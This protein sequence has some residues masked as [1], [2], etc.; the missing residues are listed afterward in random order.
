[1]NTID[2]VEEYFGDTLTE[3]TTERISA[4]P[5][6][7][8]VPLVEK[9]DAHY[10]DWFSGH[11]P[12]EQG[13]TE[14]DGDS[15]FYCLEPF[16]PENDGRALAGRYKK[17]LL[18]FPRFAVPDPLADIFYSPLVAASVL[19][20]FHWDD[21]LQDDFCDAIR[22]LAE[23]APAVKRRDL[24]LVPNPYLLFRESIQK[25]ATSEL[26]DLRDGQHAKS[27]SRSIEAAALN[28]DTIAS[29][30]RY[31]AQLKAESSGR[32]ARPSEYLTSARK[33]VAEAREKNSLAG[34]ISWIVAEHIKLAGHI[35][36]GFD[37]TAVAGDAATYAALMQ[38]CMLADNLTRSTKKD[39]RIATELV[40]YD[41]PGI[42]N[43]D[44]R[45]ILKIRQNEDA[46]EAFRKDFGS[47]IDQVHQEQPSDQ[48]EFEKEFRQA[49]DDILRPRIAEVNKT[50]SVS[51]LEKSLVP[52]ALS[53][54]AGWVAHAFLHVPQFPL[55]AAAAAIVSPVNWVTL[56]LNNRWNRGG[57][58]AAVLRDAYS[59]LL[60]KS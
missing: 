13:A 34:A 5:P 23:I 45:T 11:A 56:K 57:R 52:A 36:A 7:Q 2:I 19:G 38:E 30:E 24:M 16:P 4:A 1:M 35:C 8:L 40:R 29:Y 22:L 50:L 47:L 32:T 60:E 9:L 28:Q 51:L 42:G 10:E 21:R 27:Y 17:F 18:Y 15:Y 39:Q 20:A 25:A 54:G 31:L 14:K 12:D 37:Y 55:T 53:V 46:F 48:K 6:D 44:L 59:M 41:I 58:K 26:D 3:E 49:A 43:V 33:V